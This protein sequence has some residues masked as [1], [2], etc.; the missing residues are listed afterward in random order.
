VHAALAGFGLIQAPLLLVRAELEAGRLVEVLAAHR[1]APL[2]VN[3][4]FSSHAWLPAQ[5]RAF[6]DLAR[7]HFGLGRAG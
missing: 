5:T 1:P 4:L 6:I 3:L 7:L 2:E